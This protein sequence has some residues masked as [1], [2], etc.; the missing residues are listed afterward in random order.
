MTSPLLSGPDEMRPASPAGLP[1]PA[2]ERQWSRLTGQALQLERAGTLPWVDVAYETYGRLDPD[3][4]NAVLVCHAL[5]GDSH[6]AAHDDTASPRGWWEGLIG[7]GRALDTRRY[8]VVCPNVLGGC[9]GTTGPRS[10]HH[11]GSG[12]YGTRF[13]LITIGDMVEVQ[14]RLLRQLGVQ[15]LAL[16]VGGSMGGMQ[17]LEW[18]VRYPE[19]LQRAAVFAAPARTGALAIALNEVQ[20]Q[21]I[22]RDPGWLD[23]AYEDGEGPAAGL[24]LAR[25]VGMISYQGESALERRFGRRSQGDTGGAA[26]LYQAF[27]VESYLRHQGRKLVA[28]FDAT[29]Y[30]YLLR[31]IDLFDVSSGRG[32]LDEALARIRARLLVVGV[33][34]DMLYPPE[35][36]R[37]LAR[38]LSSLGRRVRYAELESPRGHDAFLLETEAVGNL[39][40]AVLSDAAW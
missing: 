21:A 35:Q 2:D 26:P 32:T 10:P 40:E 9:R 24:G 20:R 29:T 11:D 36:Q 14:H 1:A 38:S 3:G 27:A 13:P 16:V 31:A 19:L 25:M 4:A 34:S 23:G 17:A 7:P 6:A 37:D 22:L 39:L 5:T 28:R 15:R 12:R 33:S 18:A 8:F 30:L